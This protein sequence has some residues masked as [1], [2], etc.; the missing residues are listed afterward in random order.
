[1]IDFLGRHI[2]PIPMCTFLKTII[3]HFFYNKSALRLLA[4][5]KLLSHVKLINMSRVTCQ[6]SRVTCHVSHVIFLFYFLGGQ[7]GEAYRWRVC[8]QRGLP[9]LVKT[10]TN[11]F[12]KMCI[13]WNSAYY[14]FSSTTDL[15]ETIDAAYIG[16][17]KL[18]IQDMYEIQVTIR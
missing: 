18:S 9:R 7:S 1:M 14:G 6:V 16:L 11:F 2:L 5:F 17:W 10:E 15:S 12:V 3:A 4:N 8:Y 13:Q